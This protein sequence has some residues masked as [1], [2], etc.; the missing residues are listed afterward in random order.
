MA[1]DDSL[2]LHANT[3]RKQDPRRRVYIVR[4]RLAAGVLE[5]VAVYPLLLPLMRLAVDR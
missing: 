3:S 2:G 5:S 4:F 1:E